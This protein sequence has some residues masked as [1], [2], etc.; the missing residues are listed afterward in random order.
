MWLREEVFR[1]VVEQSWSR[2]YGLDIFQRIEKCRQDIWRWGRSYNKDFQLQIDQCK[3]MLEVLRPR[4]DPQSSVE[5]DRVERELLTLLEQQHI[6]WRQRAKE[7]WWKDGNLNTMFF[8]NSVKARQGR[9]QV[10]KLRNEDGSHVTPAD[11]ANLERPVAMEEVTLFYRQF[12]ET[13]KLPTRANDTLIVL[14]PKKPVPE[15]MKDLRPI[16]LCNVLYKIAAKVCANRLKGLLDKIISQSQSAFVPGRLITDNIMLDFEA[17]HYLKRKT[18]SRT[19]VG[20]LKIDMSKAYDRVEWRFLRAVMMKMGFSLKWVNILLETVSCVKYHILYEQ[21]H[22]GPIILERGLRQ[23]DPLSPY[24]FLMVVKGL[25]ALI[26]NRMRRGLL[27]GIHI[28]REAPPSSHLLF[29]DDCFL[30]LCAN[31]E[32]SLEMK[33][34]LDMYAEASGLLVNYDK[35]VVC[36]SANVDVHSRTQVSNILGVEQGDTAGRYL[37]LPSLVGRNKKEILGFLKEK[38]LNRVRSWN[39]RFLSRAGREF[40]LK[41]VLQALPC[42]AMM[43]FMLPAS[44]C[45]EIEVILNRYWWTR[46][47]KNVAGLRWK[48][49]GALSVPKAK[50]GLGFKDLRNM[51]LA[52]LELG[53]NPSF[54]WCGIMGSQ[55]V[56][57]QWERRS[58]GDG[59][60]TTIGSDPWLVMEADPY[61]RTNL[62]H[63]IM[64]T[65]VSSLLRGDGAGWDV[66]CVSDVFDE[67]D[68]RCILNIPVSIRNL[69]TPGYG[70]G[71]LKGDILNDRVWRRIQFDRESVLRSAITFWH[72]WRT[73]NVGS[74]N[75]AVVHSNAETWRPSAAD[76]LKINTGAAFCVEENVMGL[77]WVLRDEDGRFLAARSTCVAGMHTVVEAE[78]LCL[79]EA[80]IWLRGTGMGNVDSFGFLVDDVKHVASMIDGVSFQYVKRSANRA[81]LA[82]AREAV[83]VSGP[84]E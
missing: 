58:I 43:V 82:V 46:S 20:A 55:H 69:L 32:E 80:L 26:D 42:Y 18:Q 11:N 76:R 52:L 79:R 59:R 15:T 75:E 48:S 6:Y 25:S 10:T 84:G 74:H 66:A 34:V 63:S 50:G 37:G 51:N 41:N 38:I 64:V 78:V 9:N 81:A 73:V 49:W 39:T 28:A 45:R 3:K 5:Y 60:T 44:L 54:V 56:V 61:V 21:K 2:S 47:V 13:A 4:S 67:R 68:A 1:E 65:L 71:I 31:M 22:L 16:A 70:V 14:I 7:H 23:G 17:H 12:I 19:G 72:N 33:R 27:Q 77:G 53:T 24:L 62:N 83:S 8:H 57:P 30:F 29:A 35:S 36:F 40:L